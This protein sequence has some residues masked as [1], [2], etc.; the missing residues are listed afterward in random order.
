MKITLNELRNVIKTILK[1]E[2]SKTGLFNKLDNELYNIMTTHALTDSKT[3]KPIQKERLL[4]LFKKLT[5]DMEIIDYKKMLDSYEDSIS[6]E[7]DNKLIN[8]Y[9][10]EYDLEKSELFEN[11]KAEFIRYL[12]K[13][14]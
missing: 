10:G 2:H 3:L 6:D 7:V 13:N 11:L 12:N 4:N 1:E 8:K 5:S 9:S 14:I